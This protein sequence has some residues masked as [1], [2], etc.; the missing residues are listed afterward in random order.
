MRIA[1]CQTSAVVGERADNRERLEAVIREAAGSGSSGGGENGGDNVVV[2]PEL[3][4]TG[5]SFTGREELAE[6]AEV[7]E[8]SESATLTAWHQL[9]RELGIVLVGGF[10]EAGLDG[11]FYNS[12]AIVDATGV[13]AVYRKAHLWD[14]EKLIFAQGNDLPPVVDTAFGRIGLMICYDIEF[15]EWVREISLRGADLL[16]CPVNWP[17]LPH[18]ADEK[19]SEVIKVQALASMNRIF[20]AIADRALTDRDQEWSGASIIVDPDGFPLT[21]LATGSDNIF[22]AD[23]DLTLARDKDINAHNNVLADRRTDLYQ[24]IEGLI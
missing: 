2:I 19:P 12:S 24:H 11:N 17:L 15:P 1:V 4:N 10:A 13:R 16:C 8:L 23:V 5:Y 14:A 22:Y 20:I 3:A 7:A 18:P 21:T 9:A 6:L